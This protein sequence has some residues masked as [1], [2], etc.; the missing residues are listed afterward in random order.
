[1]ATER[2]K[3][4]GDSIQLGKLTVD[5]TTGQEAVEGGHPLYRGPTASDRFFCLATCPN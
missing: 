3:R 4:P 1:M 5:I 2:L